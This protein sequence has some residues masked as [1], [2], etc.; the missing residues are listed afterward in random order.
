MMRGRIVVFVALAVAIAFLGFYAGWSASTPE[1]VAEA[2]G[3]PLG[4]L[5]EPA[6]GAGS[7]PSRRPA[8]RSPKGSAVQ[9]AAPTGST[10]QASIPNAGAH[11]AATTAQPGHKPAAPPASQ[12]QHRTGPVRFGTV[13]TSGADND[14]GIADDRRAL[15]TTFSDL[16]V[17]VGNGEVTEPDAAPVLL[18]DAAPHRRRER[19]DAQGARPGLCL[20]SR[21]RDGTADPPRGRPVTVKDIPADSDFDLLQTLELPASP[22]TTYQLSPDIELHQRDGTAGDGYLNILSIDIEIT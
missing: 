22:A 14:T 12:L 11:P 9:A 21:R 7:V 8:T 13:T 1:A 3:T 6:D 18:H 20:H 5:V 15:T 2:A 10:P 4:S 17:T 16:E 19:G